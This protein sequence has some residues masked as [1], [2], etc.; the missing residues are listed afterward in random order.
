MCAEA[1]WRWAG[2]VDAGCGERGWWGRRGQSI[3]FFGGWCPLGV[4]GWRGMDGAETA[5]VEAVMCAC[6]LRAG[7]LVR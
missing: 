4:E 3:Y 2:G 1:G 6:Y 7:G 5:V